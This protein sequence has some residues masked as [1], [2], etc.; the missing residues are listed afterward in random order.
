MQYL[1]DKNLP[2]LDDDQCALCEKYITGEEVKHELNKMKIDI[3]TGYECFT[4]EAF[5]NHAKVPLLLLFKMAFLK[6]ELSTSQ[7]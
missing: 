6:K 7:K 2:K 3:S 1:Q 5:W 4:K